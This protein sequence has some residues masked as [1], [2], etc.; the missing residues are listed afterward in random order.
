MGKKLREMTWDDY[1]ISKHRYKEL[2]AFCLQY[3]EKKSKI[4]RGIS[5]VNY[6]GLPKGTLKGDGLTLQA[7]RNVS[8]MSDCRIIEEAAVKANKLIAP[9]ILKSVTNDM[10]YEYIEYDERLG[11]IPV[12]KTDFYAYR[13]LFYHYLDIL[14]CEKRQK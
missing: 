5:G 13:R 1:G 7:I 2:S 11:R 10:S 12:G 14:Q 8:Y 4:N 3:G 9:Y 6:D